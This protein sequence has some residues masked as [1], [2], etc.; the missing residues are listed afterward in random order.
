MKLNTATLLI[1]LPLPPKAC[2]PNARCHWAAKSRAV[3]QARQDGWLAAVAAMRATAWYGGV[4]PR[5]ENAKATV[6]YFTRTK[7][8][9]DPDNAISILKAVFDGLADAGIVAN[10][11]GLWP[12]LAP[13]WHQVDKNNPRV[14]IEVAECVMVP[15]E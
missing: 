12:V 6:R 9:M 13:D 4:P 15:K 10:D 11:R 1:A 5:W 3:K 7:H 14:E 2:S 8:R